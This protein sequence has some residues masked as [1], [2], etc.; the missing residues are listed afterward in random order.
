MSAA[1]GVWA[2]IQSTKYI[3]KNNIKGDFVECG[4]WRGGIPLAIAM[5]LKDLNS[6]KKIFLYDTYEGMTKPSEFDIDYMG[7]TPEKKFARLNKDTHNE[8]YFASLEDVKSQFIQTSLID[9]AIFIKGDVCKTLKEKDNLPKEISLLRLNTDWYESTKVEMDI[10]YPL[11]SKDGVLLADTYGYW[12]GGRKA[13]DE[14]LEN[15]NL[16][17]KCLFW[18]ID[19]DE[20]GFIKK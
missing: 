7:K 13:I 18:K 20:R 5:V 1:E 16:T 9:K 8:W 12:D 11:L 4:V 17:N 2:A 19:R 15:N 6:D 3:V 14:Y 10:L